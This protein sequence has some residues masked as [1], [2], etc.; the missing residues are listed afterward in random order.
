MANPITLDALRILDAIDRKKS[1]AAAADELFRVPSAIS[2]TVKKLEE[3]LGVTIFDRTKRKAEFTPTGQLLLKQGRLI[4]QATDELSH[5]V[6]QIEKGWELELRICVDNILTFDPI[7]EL[8]AQFQRE[9]PHVEIKLIEEVMEG[10]WDAIESERCDLAI[11]VPGD[12]ISS[13][14]DSLPIG[15]IEFVFAVS[16][17]HPLTLQ[18][19]PVTVEQIKE[20]P[21][22]VVADSSRGLPPRSIRVL[23]GQRRITVPTVEKKI[24]AQMLGL[25][26]GY[27]P[28][29]RVEQEL[30]TGQLVALEVAPAQSRVSPISIA[31]NKSNKGKALRWFIEKLAG[32]NRNR[33]IMS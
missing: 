31:W 16:R 4:L 24:S 14:Y 32:M 5:H 23:E 2:Y 13:R 8:M 15:D 10:N 20:Y 29:F 25:G 22:I 12:P 11:G 6:V 17:G 26:V 30:Q 21:S 19:S 1:F 9:H 7:Y 3:D 18:P 33:L 27:L 28:I